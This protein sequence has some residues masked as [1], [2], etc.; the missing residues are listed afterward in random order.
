MEIEIIF[1]WDEDHF[2]DNWIR[3]ME[4]ESGFVVWDSNTDY[5]GRFAFQLHESTMI[6]LC[7]SKMATYVLDVYDKFG[8]G[9]TNGQITVYRDGSPVETLE[10]S[11]E[12]NVRLR[13]EPLVT[14]SPTVT[15]T[16]SPSTAPSQTPTASPP[17][18][19][20]TSRPTQPTPKDISFPSSSGTQSKNQSPWHCVMF[21]GTIFSV[22]A[23]DCYA[24]R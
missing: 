7:V 6:D 24:S 19:D 15:P 22:I 5:D 9:F 17:I 11:F 2:T 16:V 21:V 10:G 3:L 23:L 1:L 12:R 8:N 18:E 20:R 13:I 4:D 14:M